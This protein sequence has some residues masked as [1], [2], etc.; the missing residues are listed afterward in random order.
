MEK[1]PVSQCPSPLFFFDMSFK[2]FR[3]ERDLCCNVLKN[4]VH[5]FMISHILT[6]TLNKLCCSILMKDYCFIFNTILEG[7]ENK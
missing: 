1:R 6:Q 7:L 3:L 2:M 4:K 5:Y